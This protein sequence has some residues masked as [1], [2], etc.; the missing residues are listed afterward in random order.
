MSYTIGNIIYGTPCSE[1]FLDDLVYNNR[2][3]VL[4]KPP[5]T[6]LYSSGGGPGP[7]YVGVKLR[8]IDE[9]KDVRLL[10]L[11]NTFLT[12]DNINELRRLFGKIPKKYQKYFM[13]SPDYWIVWSSS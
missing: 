8:E 5:F 6:E 7:A 11:T 10:D 3:D 1:E 2:T 9:T 13:D 12:E 4:K